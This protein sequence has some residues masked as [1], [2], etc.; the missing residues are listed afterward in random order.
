MNFPSL[1]LAPRATL[2]ITALMLGAC[3]DQDALRDSH[4]DHDHTEVETSG[5]LVY[6]KA[7]G[8]AS[9]VYV[10]DLHDNEIAGEF[11][12]ANAPS[13]IYSSPE[14]RYAVVLQRT[15]DKTSFIDGGVWQEDH[16][17]HLHDYVEAPLKLALEIDGARPTHYEVHE[18]LAALFLDGVAPDQV[19][20]IR[21]FSDESL[22]LGRM[23][24][25]LDLPRFMHGTAEPRGDYLLTTFRAEGASGTL[26]SA[27][28]LYQ[29]S[30]PV[31][32]ASTGSASRPATAC[33]A[34]F[35]TS[36][37][38]PSVAPMVCWW[39]S[40]PAAPSPQA[41]SPIRPA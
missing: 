7:D 1:G 41:S 20:G 25:S 5:R 22:E 6:G 23:E 3:N 39:S 2:L 36:T 15:N 16:G 19:A 38:R 13:A 10:Y 18:E 17:D 12:F 9:R 11:P 31:M 29:R 26:P 35:P 14:R 40:R 34:A 21:T 37:T 27:V 30:G 8:A 28:E 24:A 33:T 4:D 32:S